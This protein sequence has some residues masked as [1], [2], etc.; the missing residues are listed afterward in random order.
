MSFQEV[1]SLEGEIARL[2]KLFVREKDWDGRKRLADDI[3][4]H[5]RRLK[6]LE[7][8]AFLSAKVHPEE[9]I[10]RFQREQDACVFRPLEDMVEA[11][12]KTPFSPEAYEASKQQ[13]EAL[14][15]MI[16]EQQRV[17][18]DGTPYRAL[19]ERLWQISVAEDD[20][21]ESHRKLSR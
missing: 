5:C 15:T 13:I 2:E 19:L 9:W 12:A 16:I 3:I 6:E 1:K 17:A 11:L 7:K 14:L 4:G 10:E 8:R 20:N 21:F 18:R